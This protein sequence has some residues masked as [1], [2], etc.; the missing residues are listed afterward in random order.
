MTLYEKCL[1]DV[2]FVGYFTI[3][4]WAKQKKKEDDDNH[5]LTSL[6][7][8][9]AWSNNDQNEY[10]HKFWVTFHQLI[11]KICLHT[12]KWNKIK[13]SYAFRWG[14]FYRILTFRNLSISLNS[15]MHFIRNMFY[16]E[17][18]LLRKTTHKHEHKTSFYYKTFVSLYV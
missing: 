4:Q 17:L 8:H 3:R 9:D 13:L 14:P 15:K 6:I 7:T 5:H 12:I 10:T 1:L 11:I 16:T 2:C 18:L